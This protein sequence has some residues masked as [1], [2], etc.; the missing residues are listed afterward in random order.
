V[1]LPRPKIKVLKRWRDSSEIE[2]VGNC[3]RP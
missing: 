2:G 1:Q 3:T